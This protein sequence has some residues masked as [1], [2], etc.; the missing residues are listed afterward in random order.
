MM[1]PYMYQMVECATECRRPYP[2]RIFFAIVTLFAL[3]MTMHVLSQTAGGLPSIFFYF[4]N[5]RSH[6]K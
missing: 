3:V 4:G 2:E 5:S 1:W 6:H